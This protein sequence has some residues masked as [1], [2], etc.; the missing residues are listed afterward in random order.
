R[1]GDPEK[2]R[3]IPRGNARLLIHSAATREVR[4]W[5]DV[6]RHEKAARPL[7]RRWAAVVGR[8]AC[9]LRDTPHYVNHPGSASG[10]EWGAWP[11]RRSGFP[12]KGT[13]KPHGP[14]IRRRFYRET[15][16][17]RDLLRRLLTT[18]RALCERA[19]GRDWTARRSARVDRAL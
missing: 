10:K 7:A 5:L 2:W 16:A 14:R 6:R 18:A 15:L 12:V 17:A 13:P 11:Q 1:R 3:P 9:G 19:I 4:G 8:S